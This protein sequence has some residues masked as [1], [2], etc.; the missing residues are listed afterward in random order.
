MVNP[1][2]KEIGTIFI[3]V[4]NVEKA[5]D[6]YCELLGLPADG[7]IKLGHLYVL[8]LDG[9]NIVL[10][11]KIYQ[12]ENI[13]ST[14][15]FHFNTNHIKDAYQYIHGKGVEVTTEIEHGHWFNFKDPDGNHLMICRC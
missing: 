1:I 13:I 7:E 8:S 9:I 4:S 14:P 10:D 6:W 3:P 2:S 5:R 11:S 12:P 15:L